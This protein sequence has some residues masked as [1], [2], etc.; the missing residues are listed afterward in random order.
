MVGSDVAV[1][2]ASA[3]A[4]STDIPVHSTVSNLDIERGLALFDLYGSNVRIIIEIL[5]EPS[6]EAT[7]HNQ[8][9]SAAAKIARDFSTT[10]QELLILDFSSKDVSSKIFMLRPKD[11]VSR[12]PALIIPTAFLLESFALALCRS[13]EA[14]QHSVLAMLNSH[15]TLRSP[16]GWMFENM[17]HVII[18]D[19]KRPR[20]KIYNMA[21][22]EYT[23]PAPEEMISGNSALRGIKREFRP[24][25]WRPLE[26]NYEGVDSVLR[27]GNHVWALQYTTVS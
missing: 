11:L 2:L 15:P 23:I 12:L 8:I 24:F 3:T 5:D 9:Q 27:C 14:Q 20:L 6:L 22:K 19:S 10:F 26:S 4:L 21:R 18:A 1:C 13:A 16:A 25:Y 7:Y 17:A